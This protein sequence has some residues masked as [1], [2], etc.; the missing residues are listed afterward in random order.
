MEHLRD[1]ETLKYNFLRPLVC[2]SGV[3]IQFI[4]IWKGWYFIHINQIFIIDS[5]ADFLC[6]VLSFRFIVQNV[7]K[8]KSVSPL[9]SE[10]E[11][12]EIIVNRNLLM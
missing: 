2:L 7:K 10:V 4:I 1:Q 11:T 12:L 8:R 5:E 9:L 6:D 3:W